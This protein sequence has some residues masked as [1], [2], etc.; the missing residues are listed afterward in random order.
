MLP[1]VAALAAALIFLAVP[2]HAVAP[3]SKATCGNKKASFLFWPNGHGQIDSAGFPEYRTPHLEVYP[4]FH[5]K[6]FP[7]ATN[8]NAEP[9][10]ATINSNACEL[11]SPDPLSGQVPHKAKRTKATNI[12]CNFGQKMRLEFTQLNNGVKVTGIRKDGT[13]VIELTILNSGSKALFNKQRCDA[14]DPP[15]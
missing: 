14:K 4:G 5:S 15:K 8:A 13:K 2:V 7:P 6:T 1:L 10:S 12:Q 11:T 9:G 3:S